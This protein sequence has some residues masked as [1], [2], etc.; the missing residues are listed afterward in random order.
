MI[1]KSLMAAII[2]FTSTNL[3]AEPNTT[4][5]SHPDKT[6]ISDN[7]VNLN[8]CY[9]DNRGALHEEMNVEP[10][11][12]RNKSG[13]PFHVRENESSLA[14]VIMVVLLIPLLIIL[15]FSRF[16]KSAK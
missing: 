5:C 16:T 7:G 14:E 13:F 3:I 11:K 9:V 15:L 2:F 10:N 6:L 4:F 1:K 12:T 8:F